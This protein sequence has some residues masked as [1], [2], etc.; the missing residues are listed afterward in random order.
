VKRYYLTLLGLTIALSACSAVASTPST[1]QI[2]SEIYTQGAQTLV[3][4]NTPASSPTPLPVSTST[5][6]PKPTLNPPTAA[7]TIVS[8]NV[9]IMEAHGVYVSWQPD[10]DIRVDYALCNSSAYFEDT[11]IPDG[12]E[13]TPGESFEKIWTIQNTGF[14]AWKANYM[15]RFFNGDSMSGLDTEIGKA[16]A[17]GRQAK[18]SITLT[19]PALE[20][21]YTGYWILADEYGTAFGMPFYVQIVVEN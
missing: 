7:P 5:P 4:M 16:V 10:A 21:T 18:I 6:T 13:F 2:V 9:P 15:V 8:L 20:G 14:C 3:A 19:A 17:S 1:D 11:T 12:T